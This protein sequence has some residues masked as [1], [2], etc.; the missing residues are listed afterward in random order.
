MTNSAEVFKILQ[1]SLENGM[2]NSAIAAIEYI[3]D[4]KEKEIYSLWIDLVDNAINSTHDKDELIKRHKNL[5]EEM[6]SHYVLKHLIVEFNLYEDIDLKIQICDEFI[7]E[8]PLDSILYRNYKIEY[9]YRKSSLEDFPLELEQRIFEERKNLFE[10]SPLD[11]GNLDLL[12]IGAYDLKVSLHK[13]SEYYYARLKIFEEADFK[14]ETIVEEVFALI[15]NFFFENKCWEI[16]CDLSKTDL[17]KFDYPFITTRLTFAL[18]EEDQNE[19][20]IVN[21]LNLNFYDDWTFYN[22][23]VLYSCEGFNIVSSYYRDKIGNVENI[24]RLAGV[25]SKD[26]TIAST[27]LVSPKDTILDVR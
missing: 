27:I 10:V 4:S 2:P 12:I 23:S 8:K 13:M 21:L 7:Q 11:C 1:L 9:L 26:S 20:A 25:D 24:Y 5:Y 14:Q 17:S 6:P 15:V 22:L 19:N 16:L 3:P 18:V